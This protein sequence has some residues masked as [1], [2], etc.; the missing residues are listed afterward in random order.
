[1]RALVTGGAGF[2]GSNVA[3]R[4]AADGRDVVAADTFGSAHFANLVDFPGDVLTLRSPDDVESMVALGPFDAIFHQASITGVVSSTGDDTSQQGSLQQ[5]MLRNNVEQFRAIL[6][7]AV[8]TQARVVWASS[9]SIYGRGPVPMVESQ[10]PDPLN[11]YAFS[12]LTME[13]MASRYAERLAHPIVGL[14]YTNVYGPGEDHKGKL[15]SMIH[16][17]A[18]QMRA[19]QRPRIFEPGT[20]RRDFVYID[21]CVAANLLACKAKASGVCNV[22][23]GQSWTF[24]EVV[25]QLNRALKT[26][27]QPDYFKNPYAFTQ[28][29]TEADL[30]QARKLIG[31]EPKFD[32]ASGIDA[33]L[34]S[35]KLGISV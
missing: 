14:R 18:R 15:A 29:W 24:N 22:G 17:L 35:G 26:D 33:Y 13:R 8:R 2:I 20:Q 7:W 6:D 19:G 1:M 21:D 12:K 11:I 4:L 25:A 28:D 5:T 3:K 34:A 27:L 16:Q 30:T 23:A 9:C 32:I 10:P 31:Y